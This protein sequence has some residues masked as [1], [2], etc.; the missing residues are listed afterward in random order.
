[1]SIPRA[2]RKV[3]VLLVLVVGAFALT[4]GDQA[5]PS[6]AASDRLAQDHPERR[7]LN[8]HTIWALEDADPLVQFV[9]NKKPPPPPACTPYELLCD[10]FSPP[11]LS[12]VGMR[13]AVGSPRIRTSSLRADSLDS[14]KR[15]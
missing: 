14:G 10:E 6:S 1:M 12:W 13:L 15:P 4:F 7:G 8:P 3:A 5:A 2:L 9:S 11:L